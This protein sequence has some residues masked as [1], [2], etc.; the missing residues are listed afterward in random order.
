MPF[1]L[2]FQIDPFACNPGSPASCGR[3]QVL[4]CDDMY[5]V[6]RQLLRH[7]LASVLER[8]LQKPHKVRC[9]NQEAMGKIKKKKSK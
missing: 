8:S 2:F 3:R 1:F 9:K 4:M 6:G 7:V 5:P